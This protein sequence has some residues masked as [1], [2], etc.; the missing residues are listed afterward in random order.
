MFWK[1][2]IAAPA[3]WQE[4]LA[5]FDQKPPRNTAIP[6][7]RF[8]VM[9][10]E[11][12]GLDP[13]RDKLLSIAGIPVENYTMRIQ[14]SFACLL[15]QKKPPGR[16]SIAIHG[17]LPDTRLQTRSFEA[18]LPDLLSKIANR[19]IVGHHIRFDLQ[20]LN[21]A[22]QAI[23]GDSLKNDV[24][25]TAELARRLAPFREKRNNSGIS[26]D[27]LCAHYSLKR[28]GRHTAA[29]DSFLTARILCTQLKAL[30]RQGLRTK[31]DLLRKPL[32]IHRY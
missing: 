1:K 3:Y 15:E 12:T 32:K 30:E 25:D 31:R 6:V 7:L 10:T 2:K 27:E 21:K 26:L 8:W 5:T 4:Y 11:T 17:I 23:T 14:D 20:V 29:G 18:I 22:I 28:H 16:D 9:D 19:I 24:L 13:R